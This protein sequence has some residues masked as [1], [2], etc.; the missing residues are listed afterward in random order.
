MGALQGRTLTTGDGIGAGGDA[1]LLDISGLRL[2]YG[3]VVVLDGVDLSVMPGELFVLLGGS[4]SGKT[5][6]LRAIA[7]LTKPDGGTI[8]L[9][10][11]PIDDLPPHRR[12]VNTMF[13]SYALFPHLT[14]AGNVAFGLRRRGLRLAVVRDRVAEMLEL[15]QLRSLER[16]RPH[17]LS[18]GQRQRVALARSLAPRPAL[19]LLDEPLSALDPALRAATRAELMRVQADTGTTFI[20][21]THDQQEALTMASRIGVMRHGLI[22]QVGTPATLYEQPA[23]RFVAEFVGAAN[24]LPARIEAADD[25]GTL[26]AIEGVGMVRGRASAF[27]PGDAC[28]VALRP[29]RLRLAREGETPENRAPGFLV[30]SAYGGETLL[31]TVRLTNGTS[32]RVAEPLGRGLAAR[33]AGVGEAV[34]V[35]WPADACIL[36]PP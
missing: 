24:V 1:P 2:R 3:P 10:G 31:H 22:A 21:V 5:T 26:V 19:L 20:L 27:A 6:L 18:G 25:T 11:S 13:Q 28:L 35:D 23:S 4:G 7:G 15:V 30:Q 9:R 17:E 16:R 34:I 29:E 32:L 33:S 36:L 12:P 8:R 14:V